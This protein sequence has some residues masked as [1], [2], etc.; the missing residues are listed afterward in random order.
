MDITLER[1]K[2]YII[3]EVN[4]DGVGFDCGQKIQLERLGLLG[5]RE[6]AELLGGQLIIEAAPGR[7]AHL[8]VRIPDDHGATQ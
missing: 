2:G 8:F 7:G 1:V 6:R 4:D 3:L 5:I